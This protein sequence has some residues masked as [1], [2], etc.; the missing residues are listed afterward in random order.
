MSLP[1]RGASAR[2]V[3]AC[4]PR[5][6]PPLAVARHRDGRSEETG[7]RTRFR[8]VLAVRHTHGAQFGRSVSRR[9]LRTV[10]LCSDF[11]FHA[12]LTQKVC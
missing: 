6:I 10:P 7:I 12:L 9:F 5:L 4:L 8:S 1:A 3:A 2:G 11:A